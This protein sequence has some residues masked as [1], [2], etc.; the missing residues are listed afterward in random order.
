MDCTK[1]TIFRLDGHNFSS[2]V[3]KEKLTRPFDE[4]F[5]LAMQAT[6]RACFSYYPGASHCFVGSDEITVVLAPQTQLPFSG[7]QDK[8]VS[9]LAGFATAN[10]CPS[11][12][13]HHPH[14][15]C[16]VWQVDSLEDVTANIQERITFTL[17]NTRMMFAQHVISH[18]RL[19]KLSSVQAVELALTEGH[20]FASVPDNVKYGILM[21]KVQKKFVRGDVEY[22]R[23]VIECVSVSHV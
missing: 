17:K 15:D 9:L 7:R 22:V 19:H 8:L 21:T 3:K 2:F 1:W 4:G 23:R 13:E 12:P 11:Y 6:A 16:R 10:F 20:D 18:K 5:T 14:F